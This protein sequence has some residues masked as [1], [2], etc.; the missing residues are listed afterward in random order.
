M[1]MNVDDYHR[2]CLF[3]VCRLP[4]CLSLIH[5]VDGLAQSLGAKL[6]RDPMTGL[7]LQPREANRQN[8]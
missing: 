8:H 2:G 4:V 3:V 1:S 6:K 5:M 7:S